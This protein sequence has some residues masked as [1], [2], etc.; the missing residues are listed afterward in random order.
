MTD[1]LR[2][3]DSHRLSPHIYAN[4]TKVYGFCQLTSATALVANITNCIESAMSWMQSNRLQ[5]NLD[6]TEQLWCSTVRQ[7]HQIPPSPLLIDG[8]SITPV[9]SACDLRI[10]IDCNLSMRMHVQ[11]NMSWC[12]A[13][14]R[15]LRQIRRYVPSATPQKLMFTLVHSR[16]D[17]GNGVLVGFLVQVHLMHRLQSVLNDHILMLSSVC[18][19]CRL[20]NE[21]STSW[22]SW[23]T[24]FSM[25]MH[26][27][28][29]LVHWS[30]LT[31]CQDDDQSVLPIT[32]AS[33]YHQSNC[34]QSVAEPSWLQLH[35]SG[36]DCQLMSSWQI[37]CQPFVEY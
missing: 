30:A 22:L 31:T 3:I 14:L 16:L 9:Q 15:Q 4:D 21:F 7:Q 37:H 13:T 20:W 32:T 19:G 18:T 29:L 6:K 27:F 33:W 10:Y 24:K 36:T 34:Q 5:P 2:V 23:H 11:H 8:C 12:F 1:L 26:H 35:T 28:T 17:C 25:V